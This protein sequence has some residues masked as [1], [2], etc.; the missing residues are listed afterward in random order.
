MD[1]ATPNSFGEFIR[2]QREKRGLGLV[3]IEEYT[4]VNIRYLTAIETDD[5]DN[6]P[7]QAY[8][9]GFIRSYA[10]ALGLD[11]DDTVDTYHYHHGKYLEELEMG[12]RR[13]VS[14]MGHRVPVRYLALTLGGI[15]AVMVITWIV[16]SGVWQYACRPAPVTEPAAVATTPPTYQR[17]PGD[18]GMIR[19]E[20]IATGT[21][22]VQIKLDDYTEL[23]ERLVEGDRRTWHAAKNIKVLVGEWNLVEILKNGIRMKTPED[24]GT[25]VLE[26]SSSPAEYL[27]TLQPTE[28]AIDG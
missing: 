21:T 11:E 16:G 6:Y 2:E 1:E 24:G 5:F 27:T 20:V 12:R 26:A 23:S 4:R 22:W 15:V 10:R 9:L 25:L 8:A 14:V 17:Q 19:L 7:P 18:P 13:S 28:V 3:A